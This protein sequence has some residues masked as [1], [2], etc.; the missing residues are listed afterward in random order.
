MGYDSLLRDAGEVIKVEVSMREPLLTPVVQSPARTL[1]LDPISRSAAVPSFP[2]PCLSLEEAMAEKLRALSRRDVAIRDFYDIDHA[3]RE[4]GVQLD[5]PKLLGLVRRKLTV[6]GNDPPDASP[7]RLRVL[8]AQLEAE[9]R[10]VLREA[11]LALFDLD[12]AIGLVAG[13]ASALL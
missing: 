1:L 13:V 11:D 9:L 6:A 3:V 5:D 10:P 8:E 4:R 2:V 7:A 12:R